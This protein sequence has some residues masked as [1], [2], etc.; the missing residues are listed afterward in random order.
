MNDKKDNPNTYPSYMRLYQSGELDERIGKLKSYY[1]N[2][3]LCPR[4]CRVNRVKGETGKCEANASLKISSAFA[5]F[6][7]ERPLVGTKGS[8]TIFFSHCGLRCVYCQNYTLSIRG[9]G[10]EVGEKR[11]AE[12]MLKLQALGCHNINL[13][14]PTHYVPGIVSSLKQAISRGLRIPIV[15]NTGG[16]EKAE[17]L[18][19]LDGIVDLYL[20]DFKYTSPEMAAAYSSEAFNYPYYV[21]IAFKEMYRQVGNLVKDKR[22]VARKGLMIRHLILPNRI[23]GSREFLEFTARELS[24]ECYINLMRQYRPEYRAREFPDI[25]R[26]ITRKEYSE[27]LECAHQLGFRNQDL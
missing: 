15:Y 16:Y 22:G 4:D 24:T 17:V 18:K 12:S 5:H 20:P 19:L 9:E 1:E 23:A 8:G 14:T 3:T 25:N 13:V 10:V 2:C 7:E 27:V 21:K 6:G 26:R 11:V